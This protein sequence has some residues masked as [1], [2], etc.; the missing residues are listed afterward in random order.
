MSATRVLKLSLSSYWRVGSGKGAEAMADALVLRDEAGLPVIPGRTIKGLLRDA[1]ALG[2][3]SGTVSPE[4]VI[5]WFGS[6]LPGEVSSD[7][8]QQERSLEEG[9]FRST[10]A[11]LWFGSAT[12]PKSWRDWA[13][14]GKDDSEVKQILSLN[15]RTSLPAAPLP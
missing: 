3:L 10:E 6:E 8:D 14:D 2:T 9:R 12:L 11:A 7:S 13:R 1:M 15:S 4:K 5:Q